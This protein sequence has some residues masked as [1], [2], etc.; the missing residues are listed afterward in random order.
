HLARALDAVRSCPDPAA[1]ARARDHLLVAEGSDWFW[2]Y[3]PHHT[4]AH[5][6]VFDRVFRGHVAAAYGE[7]GLPI[8]PDLG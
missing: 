4:A 1:R 6:P 7:I 5:E 8:P 3:G 2:W